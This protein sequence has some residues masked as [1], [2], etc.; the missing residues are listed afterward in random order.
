MLRTVARVV[1]DHSDRPIIIERKAEPNNGKLRSGYGV[2]PLGGL[3]TLVALHASTVDLP[4]WAG[5]AEICLY[6]ILQL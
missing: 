3:V 6:Y 2:S 4:T 1:V 5:R